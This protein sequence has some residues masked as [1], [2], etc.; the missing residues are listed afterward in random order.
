MSYKVCATRR[1]LKSVNRTLQVFDAS[2]WEV[3]VSSGTFNQ[4]VYQIVEDEGIYR[5]YQNGEDTTKTVSIGFIR[6]LVYEG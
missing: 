2:L 4:A 3:N 6:G 1:D 5:L